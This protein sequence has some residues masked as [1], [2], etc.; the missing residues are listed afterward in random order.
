MGATCGVFS[1]LG[2]EGSDLEL[3]VS[4][5]TSENSRGP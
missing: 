2:L 5:S 1:A 4:S 3:P